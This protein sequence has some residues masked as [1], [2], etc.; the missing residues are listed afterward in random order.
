M[1]IPRAGDSWRCVP[2]WLTEIYDEHPKGRGFLHGVR[3]IESKT[4]HTASGE[5]A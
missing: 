1:S 2:F 5:S 4:S 3:I